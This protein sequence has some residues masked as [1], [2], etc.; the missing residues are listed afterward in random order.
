MARKKHTVR[1]VNPA[2]PP[3]KKGRRAGVTAWTRNKS[4]VHLKD[5]D[6]Q[7]KLSVV[8][9]REK[10]KRWY[11]E[12]RYLGERAKEEGKGVVG[13][14][15]SKSKV[16]LDRGRALVWDS[17][18]EAQEIAERAM[19]KLQA[20]ME[21][22]PTHARKIRIDREPYCV[23]PTTYIKD[24][25]LIDRKGYCVP[26]T[27][28]TIDDPGKP[29]R[30]SRGAKKGPFSR[31]KIDPK[32]GKP[33][34]PWI[35]REGKLGGPGYTEKTQKERRKILKACEKEYGYRSCLGSIMV[36]LRS[37]ELDAKTRKTLTSDKKWLEKTYGG[38][39]SFGPRSNPSK[40]GAA[41]EDLKRMLDRTVD[42]IK[43]DYAS[44]IDL[45]DRQ[46]V[47]QLY[48]GTFTLLWTW[49]EGRGRNYDRFNESM[50]WKPPTQAAS[51]WVKD[52]TDARHRTQVMAAYKRRWPEAHDWM[53]KHKMGQRKS[54]RS[55]PEDR[56]QYGVTYS[57]VTPESAEHGDFSDQGWMHETETGTLKDVLETA[58]HFN[59]EARGK[60]DGTLW[61]DS[62]PFTEDYSTG[63]ETFYSLHVEKANGDVLD[64][65]QRELINKL[66]DDGADIESYYQDVIEELSKTY[67]PKMKRLLAEVCRSARDEG[68]ECSEPYDRSD[69]MFA[70]SVVVYP[71]GGSEQDGVDVTVQISESGVYE[72]EGGGL[73]FS[74]DLVSYGGE[75]VGGLTPYNYTSDVWVPVLDADAVEQRWDIFESGAD[76]YEAV[77]LIN[78]HLSKESAGVSTRKLKNRLL[79]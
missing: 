49:A 29:G 74:M 75:I 77:Y 5:H 33:Y 76:P 46:Q 62:H 30:R 15:G 64:K 37:S 20:S 22:N 26:A 67:V 1:A 71:R 78:E 47:V 40:A 70:W 9:L 36:L 3:H 65:E 44:S 12:M 21:D 13:Y 27:S 60:N 45:A 42:V 69:E 56:Y 4:G 73:N 68:L 8:P 10:K 51:A 25:K 50:K 34:K 7:V 31:N 38:P 72:G 14:I 43:Q 48:G 39:G 11:I 63:T 6:M 32:T 61:W 35:Q 53:V 41:P 54:K 28:Y 23:E 19:K 18:K 2:P 16:V 17:E 66:I 79:R 55:N 24:G 58:S 52:S 59:I 57:S